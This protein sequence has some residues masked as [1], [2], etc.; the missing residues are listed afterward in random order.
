MPCLALSFETPSRHAVHGLEVGAHNSLGRTTKAPPRHPTRA[1]EGASV[2]VGYLIPHMDDRGRLEQQ[3]PRGNCKPVQSPHPL[4]HQ[5]LA[6]LLQRS[7]TAIRNTS[8]IRSITAAMLA[9]DFFMEEFLP[10][11]RRE[12]VRHGH[13]T[14]RNSC[15]IAVDVVGVMCGLRD[16]R[17]PLD[18]SEHDPMSPSIF[19]KIGTSYS[20][21]SITSDVRN[22]KE[23]NAK[24]VMASEV[25]PKSCMLIGTN[26]LAEGRS[27]IQDASR[28]SSTDITGEFSNVL[29]RQIAR[30]TNR[31]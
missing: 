8:A 18:N 25:I 27:S 26:V 15:G 16:E 3:K 14:R 13:K 20:S 2:Q 31:L 19:R 28:G 22:A 11:L 9:R 4:D 17:R 10:S 6:G 7:D 30:M 12:T 23:S 21:E 1:L 24:T 29:W 5:R